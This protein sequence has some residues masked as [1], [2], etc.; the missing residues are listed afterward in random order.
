MDNVVND[1]PN[2]SVVT[3]IEIL[4]FKN[5]HKRYATCTR[6]RRLKQCV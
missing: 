6:F 1:I 4:G 5:E 3:K 2:I